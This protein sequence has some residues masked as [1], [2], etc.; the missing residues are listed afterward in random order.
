MGKGRK[1]Y[2]NRP[3]KKGPFSN[4]KKKS[5][6]NAPPLL[7]QYHVHQDDFRNSEKQQG[8]F[9]VPKKRS[10]WAVVTVAALAFLAGAIIGCPISSGCVSSG[11]KGLYMAELRVNQTHDVNL[12]VG[13]FGGCLSVAN[14]T[15]VA[16]L[17]DP[18]AA[19]NG[20]KGD[21]L[22]H[23]VTNMRTT[24][25]EDLE[26]ELSEDLHLPA[27]IQASVQD[28][29]NETVPYATQ[30][31]KQA[32]FWP[33]PVLQ[34][35]AFSFSG[36]IL[37][38]ASTAEPSHRPGY[39]ISVLVGAILG[40]FA[41][42][43]ALTE[44]VGLTQAFNGMLLS[45][46]GPGAEVP[47]L[48]S[49]NPVYIQRGG[50]VHEE[51]LLGHPKAQVT[52]EAGETSPRSFPPLPRR[53][54]RKDGPALF[55]VDMVEPFL[56]GRPSENAKSIIRHQAAKSGCRNRKRVYETKA[57]AAD[58]ISPQ[59]EIAGAASAPIQSPGPP[60]IL[61]LP[62][63]NGYEAMRAKFNF[64]ITCLTSF[65]DIDLAANACGFLQHNRRSASSLLQRW[66]SCFLTYLPSRYG[67]APFLND[68]MHCVA[69]RAAHMVGGPST[70]SLLHTALYSKALTSLAAA[71]T[72][73]PP[74]LVS[75]IY[76]ATRLLVLYESLGPPNQ[77]A[78]IFH[79]NAGIDLIKQM[80]PSS[81]MSA[82]EQVLIRSQGPYAI[83]K[84]IYKK[85]TSLFETREWQDFFD[86]AASDE[87]DADSQFLW[88][89]IGAISF[90]PGILKDIQVLAQRVP[91]CGSPEYRERRTNILERTRRVYRTFHN[92]HLSYQHRP[93][94]PASLFDMPLA[95]ES[96][97]RTRLRGIFFCSIIYF[98][99][100][101]A[102]FGPADSERA[103]SEAEAQSFAAQALLV[104]SET[105]SRDPV[106]AWHLEE[107]N[108]LSR[109]VVRTREEWDP[110]RERG[111][112]NWELSRFLLRRLQSWID[113]WAEES[114][115][116]EVG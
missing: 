59:K 9:R 25:P 15:A 5:R 58:Q 104:T 72:A 38:V 75:D 20:T 40:A 1:A 7:P 74:A 66:P 11:L 22:I 6:S 39:K 65:T 18:V 95:A 78:V 29:L 23:C 27:D 26:R 85:E 76:C 94:Y 34:T 57:S 21:P 84:A 102:T 63:Y 83:M 50:S 92:G 14:V 41:L 8:R 19:N 113:S 89:L 86:H 35:V 91:S 43:L 47:G 71:V 13:Y 79:S 2:A 109:S 54:R 112:E 100:I 110:A 67:S 37:F 101:H 98:C 16:N 12:T 81:R 30:L 44:A 49:K 87:P 111:M 10:S 97:G 70:S 52:D 99:R 114:L 77:N 36:T 108:Q 64:D 88:K 45:V 105:Q 32:F 56:T 80:G 115:A 60:L 17:T 82:F 4:K 96:P 69:A 48:A 62:S 61:P 73:E 24:D 116:A 68:A 90:L 107:R 93:P 53:S 55:F 106:L 31:Q 42:G 51:A 3:P 103:A 28:A 33:P 46:R